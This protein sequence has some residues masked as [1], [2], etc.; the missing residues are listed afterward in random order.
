MEKFIKG[1]WVKDIRINNKSNHGIFKIDHENKNSYCNE[2]GTLSVRFENAE[3][4]EPKED[5]WVIISFGDENAVITKFSNA[6]D[7]VEL[8]PCIGNLPTFLKDK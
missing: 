4:W 6:A 8:E 3:L 5:E 2:K 1:Q 7:Y